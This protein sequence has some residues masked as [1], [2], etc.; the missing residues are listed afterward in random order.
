M[1]PYKL[2]VIVPCYNVES[3]LDRCIDSLVRQSFKD[4]EIILVDDG[5]TDGTASKCNTWAE[6]DNR[7]K[8]VHKEN[9]G[10]GFARNTGLDLAGGE[11]IAFVDSDDYVAAA[12]FEN[13]VS[14]IEEDGTD[15]VICGYKDVFENRIAKEQK[16]V[17]EHHRIISAMEDYLPGIIGELPDSILGEKYC[18][19]SSWGALYKKTII[20]KYTLRFVSERIFGSEDLLFQI[21]YFLRANYISLLPDCLYNYCDN[22]TSF[23]RTYIPIK[24]FQSYIELHREVKDRTKNLLGN[25]KEYDLRLQRFLL[26][27]ALIVASVAVKTEGLGS[28]M[29]TMDCIFC[30]ET[31]QSI[32]EN[33]PIRKMRPKHRVFYS[34]MKNKNSF[35]IYLML[36]ANNLIKSIRR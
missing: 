30:N 31:L 32:L 29:K 24:L 26:N 21:D 11:Y 18:P 4:F 33:Y 19:A 2:S 6:R 22:P 17:G 35:G 16:R 13:M 36:K 10:A 28:S 5:S 14:A 27:K 23:T 15:A 12:Y 25:S 3:H 1:N 8:V 20:D 9:E 7:I 34:L